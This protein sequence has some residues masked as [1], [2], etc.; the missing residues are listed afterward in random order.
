ME[1]QLMSFKNGEV[2][3]QQEKLLPEQDILHDW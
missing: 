3:D 1:T 2:K